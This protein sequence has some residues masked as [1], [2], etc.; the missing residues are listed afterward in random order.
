MIK[1][2]FFFLYV[3][4]DIEKGEV[5]VDSCSQEEFAVLREHKD[6]TDRSFLLDRLTVK[7]RLYRRSLVCTGEKR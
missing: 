1:K 3:Q 2:E 6:E 4:S 7:K 5:L